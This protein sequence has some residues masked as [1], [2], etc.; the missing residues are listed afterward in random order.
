[1]DARRTLPSVHA[2]VEDELVRP[3]L[4]RA[5]R[6]LVTDVV[7]TVIER[8]RQDPASAPRDRAGWA[9]AIGTAL[10]ERERAF[11]APGRT[12]RLASC[13]IPI[14]VAR[15]SLMRRSSRSSRLRQATPIWSMTSPK[16][17]ADRGMITA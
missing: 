14:S 2:L 3:L 16:G 1:M 9:A 5:P 17:R 13:C 10:A 12:T 8:A 6:P 7:R 4:A 15:R 11:A